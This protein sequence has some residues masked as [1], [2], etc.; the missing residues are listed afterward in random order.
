M[1]AF[2]VSYSII[3]IVLIHILPYCL[4]CW[5][6][7][8]LSDFVSYCMFSFIS[9]FV[10]Y[11]TSVSIPCLGTYLHA[12]LHIFYILFTAYPPWCICVY[13]INLHILRSQRRNGGEI[14]PTELS[15]WNSV[16]PRSFGYRQNKASCWER[17]IYE[18]WNGSLSSYRAIKSRRY[19]LSVWTGNTTW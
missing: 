8:F 9:Y 19:S 4:S 16:Q 17:L 2:F 3:D 6:F 15:R 5:A 13:D 12:K 18:E 1:K 11:S 14:F 7:W 10:S